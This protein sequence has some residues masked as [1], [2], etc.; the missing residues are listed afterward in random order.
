MASQE[1]FNDRNANDFTPE[2]RASANDM[3]SEAVRESADTDQVIG[4]IVNIMQL[5]H[6]GECEIG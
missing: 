1:I 2:F 3:V 6:K 5:M 4:H